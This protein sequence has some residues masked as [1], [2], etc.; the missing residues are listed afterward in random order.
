MFAKLLLAPLTIMVLGGEPTN[1]FQECVAVGR[2]RD[3]IAS[4]VLIGPNVVLTAASVCEEDKSGGVTRV[5]V[6]KD[7]HPKNAEGWVFK[8]K[9]VFRYT[10]FKREGLQND[11]ALLI[12]EDNVEGR[13]ATPAPRATK[14]QIEAAKE[15]VVVGFGVNDEAG[16]RG[17]GVRRQA[18]IPIVS[19]ACGKEEEQKFYG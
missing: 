5:C 14:E 4:G 18:T 16:V 1:N 15:V 17:F 13:L 6:G 8:V 2:S 3:W 7:V 9:Q 11:L 12:L 10:D 19:W